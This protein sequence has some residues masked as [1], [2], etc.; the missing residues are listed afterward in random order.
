LPRGSPCRCWRSGMQPYAS[1]R[2]SR[3]SRRMMP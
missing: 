2:S 1:P 3:S